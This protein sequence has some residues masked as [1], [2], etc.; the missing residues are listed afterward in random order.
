MRN[1]KKAFVTECYQLLCLD[2]DLIEIH[3]LEQGLISNSEVRRKE[4]FFH[5]IHIHISVFF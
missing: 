5:L 3:H 1:I 2:F 4:H